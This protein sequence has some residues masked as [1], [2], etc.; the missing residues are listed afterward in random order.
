MDAGRRRDGRDL[1]SGPRRRGV[2]PIYRPIRSAIKEELQAGVFTGMWHLITIHFALSALALGIIAVRGG[3]DLTA[4]LIAAQFAGY[5][6]AYLAVS[7][8]LG[9]VF[10]LFQSLP[11]SITALLA[12]AGA[13]SGQ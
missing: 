6:A 2:E 1:R 7:F 12:A 5:A 10:K 8:R 11:F 3:N 13:L 9:G 4:W